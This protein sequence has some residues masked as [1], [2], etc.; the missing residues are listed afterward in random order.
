M[1]AASTTNVR[2]PRP[3]V[4]GMTDLAN[5]NAALTRTG[6]NPIASPTDGIIA[7]KIADAEGTPP[8]PWLYT[9]QDAD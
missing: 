8:E 3:D 4:R 2:C 1:K 7:A 5:I 6:N 9:Y